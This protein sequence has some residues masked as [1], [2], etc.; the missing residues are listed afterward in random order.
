MYPPNSSPV[1][2]IESLSVL[3]VLASRRNSEIFFPV[4]SGVVVA[5]IHIFTGRE[6]ENESMES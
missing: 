5:M 3:L 2:F 4:V 1:V 6:T